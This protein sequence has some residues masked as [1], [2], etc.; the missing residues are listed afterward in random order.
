MYVR[1]WE[2]DVDAGQADAFVAAYG[3]GG[4]WAELFLRGRG[5]AGTELYR[6]TDDRTRFVT[7]DRWSSAAAWTE[8][9]E[10][11]REPY[12]AL[13]ARLAGLSLAQRALIEAD[14]EEA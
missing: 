6:H 9:L 3:A 5:Y 4:D 8:F 10:Q 1:V 7:V 12:D 13:D 11:Q 2:Y 14:V